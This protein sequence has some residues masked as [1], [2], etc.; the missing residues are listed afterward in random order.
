MMVSWNGDPQFSSIYR[1][2]SFRET[3]QRFWGRSSHAANLTGGW[4]TY[5][6]E[7]FDESSVGIMKFSTE[8][9]VIKFNG[10]SHHQAVITIRVLY[11]LCLKQIPINYINLTFSGWRCDNHLEKHEFVNGKD[12]IPY[13]K[14]KIKVLFQTT[15]QLRYTIYNG[16]I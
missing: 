11:F 1:W 14:W 8:W 7:K 15:N 5:P 12:D 9:K 10:A 13:M 4:A 16:H 3:I 6:S 2:W